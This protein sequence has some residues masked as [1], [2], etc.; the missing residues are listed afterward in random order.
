MKSQPEDS[1]LSALVSREA[2]GSGRV[3]RKIKEDGVLGGKKVCQGQGVN[4]DRLL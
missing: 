1:A 3:G 2:A 4:S